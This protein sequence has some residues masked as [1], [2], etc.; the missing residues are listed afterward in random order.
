M[1]TFHDPCTQIH[2]FLYL[3]S[4]P[5]TRNSNVWMSTWVKWVTGVTCIMCRHMS[6][7]TAHNLSLDHAEQ[8]CF[9]V[10]AQKWIWWIFHNFSR[11]FPSLGGT[12][13]PSKSEKFKFKSDCLLVKMAMI[14][15]STSSSSS[16][17]TPSPVTKEFI[18]LV[19]SKI[20]HNFLPYLPIS[21]SLWLSRILLWPIRI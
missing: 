19:S 11:P 15:F 21:I 1:T 6:H 8:L 5:G 17:S 7:V 9:H 14:Y 18:E 20:I 3:K 12:K 4:W 16:S 2:L 13:W 10:Y